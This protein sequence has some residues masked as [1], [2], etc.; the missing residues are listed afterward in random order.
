M[1]IHSFRMSLALGCAALSFPLNAALAHGVVGDRFFPATITSDDPFAADEL[2]LPTISVLRHND[3]GANVTETEA[4]FEY[5]KSIVNGFAVSVGGG[6]VDTKNAQGWDNFEITP[7]VQVFRDE[8]AEFIATLAFS[9][10]VGGSGAK[11]IADS[12]STYTPEF[13]FGKGFGDLPESMALLRPF[14]I[15]GVVGYGV[16]SKGGDTDWSWSGALEYSLNYLQTNVRDEGLGPFWSRVTPIVEFAFDTPQHGPTTGTINPGLLWS[17]QYTQFGVEAILPMN[18]ETGSNVG[19]VAQLH[20][21]V[22]DIFP[23]TLGAPIF[24]GRR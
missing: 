18:R 6:Y 23:D 22:D 20:F 7:A 4:E 19:V 1:P 8:P 2:A 15:T 10:E 16:P 24:G 5:S 3:G 11:A 9:W 17:G 21:Y 12:A 14:A 13:L